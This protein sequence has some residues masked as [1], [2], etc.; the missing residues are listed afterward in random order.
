VIPLVVMAN[1]RIDFVARWPHM[2]AAVLTGIVAW[3]RGGMLTPI[4]TGM[5][6]LYV[7]SAWQ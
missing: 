2:L 4:V 5:I 7:A 6:T 3:W 1:G